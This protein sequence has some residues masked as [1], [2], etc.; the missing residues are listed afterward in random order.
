MKYRKFGKTGEKLSALGFGCMRLPVVNGDMNNIDEPKAISIIRQAIDGGVNYIDTAWGYHGGNSEPVTAKALANGYREKVQLA[1]KLPCWLVNEPSDMDKYLNLQLEKLQT[2]HI[3]FYLLHALNRKSWE[4]MKEN[5]LFDFLPRIKADGRVR[6]VGFSFHDSYEVFEDIINAYDWD[7]CQ[8]QYNILD[9]KYQAGL[10]G[11]KLAAKKG[12]GVVIMEPL[13]GGGLTNNI[14][15]NIQEAWDNIKP[16]RT[17]VDWALSWLWDQKEVGILISGMNEPWHITENLEVASRS[18]IGTLTEDNKEQLK[19]VR[20]MYHDRIIVNCTQCA[21]CMP[22]THGVN[23]PSCFQFL[24][25]GSMINNLEE[26]KRL[27]NILV[28]EEQRA[29]HCIACGECLDKCPQQLPIPQTMEMVVEKFG[30]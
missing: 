12:M 5:G 6:Y 3:D 27:Y 13:R 16:Q 21:Y 1:T 23:I 25:H 10:K 20:D 26:G 4:N 30:S 9:E 14:P 19:N 24:N 17:P 7:F 2:D 18:G 29:S 28:K 11:L 15:E 8:I 22:C